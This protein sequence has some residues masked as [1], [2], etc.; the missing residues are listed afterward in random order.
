MVHIP[1]DV[2][3][4]RRC[5]DST[6]APAACELSPVATRKPAAKSAA[7]RNKRRPW[8]KRLLILLACALVVPILEVGAVRF[9][10]PPVTPL[11]V[12][13]R[14]EAKFSRHPSRTLYEWT[15]LRRIPLV[16]LRDVWLSE[17]ERF[18]LHHGFDY[19]EIA[20]DIAEAERK[21][22]PARGAS[23]ITQQ[24]ARSTFLWQGRSWVRKGLEAYYTVLME[25]LLPKRRILELYANVIEMGD[26]I[27]G[28]QAA[29]EYYF[30]I[31]A[32]KLDA[33]QAALLAAML[34]NPREWDPRRPVAA[35]AR[36]VQRIREKEGH[37]PAALLR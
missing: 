8:A 31:P 35:L 19:R 32:A 4:F 5:A 29:S 27:Y 9:I 30:G 17:D 36:R 23:T 22:K 37:F 13:R 6:F 33:E 15:P 25:A 12:L 34:P 16:F 26:G 14:V 18:F 21:G 3:G 10:D 24:C 20:R 7:P 28:V 1:A 2:K 11:M